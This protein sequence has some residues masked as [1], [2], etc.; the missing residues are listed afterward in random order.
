[1]SPTADIYD[2]ALEFG[3]SAIM[4]SAYAIGRVGVDLTRVELAT[5]LDTQAFDF[6]LTGG[7]L[8]WAPSRDSNRWMRAYDAVTAQGSFVGFSGAGGWRSADD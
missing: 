7:S 5:V 1:V 4:Q 6:G 3:Y 8:M 2:A